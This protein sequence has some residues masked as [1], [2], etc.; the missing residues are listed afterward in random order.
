MNPVFAFIGLI[1][2]LASDP[3]DKIIK[4]ED[5]VQN[6]YPRLSKDAKE[7]LYQSNRSGKWQL[8]ICDMNGKDLVQLTKDSSDNNLP[9]W[10]HENEKIAFVSD[11]TGDEDIY[12]MS[13]HGSG[14]KNI[15]HHPGRDIHPYFSPDGRYILFFSDRVGNQFDI[16]R[17][18]LADGK[19]ERLTDTPED[20]TCA[21]YSP[22]MSLIVYLKNSVFS[23]D[24]YLL[25]VRNFLP[26]NLSKTPG[27]YHGWPMFSYDGRW[28]YY[29]SMENGTYSIY[30][31]R[32][33]GSNKEPVKE[34]KPGEEFA[35]VNVSRDGTFM[36]YNIK[37]GH[38]IWIEYSVLERK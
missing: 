11:R 32:T 9:D 3:G 28:V 6:A 12:L 36:I 17:Y 15:T 18:S 24:V 14:I 31:I 7:I 16:Y 1:I 19:T 13:R 29:S 34:A 23:D 25:P 38:T 30:R 33:D 10:D 21:R 20:E 8:Y 37:L 22:D 27:V 2:L 5:S 35:R 26:E 4:K